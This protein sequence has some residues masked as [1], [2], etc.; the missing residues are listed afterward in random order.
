MRLLKRIDYYTL[1]QFTKLFLATFFVSLFVFL[2]QFLWKYVD[3]MVGKG[4]G[5]NVLAEF[6]FYA[7]VSLV[8][9]ALP[10]SIMLASLM[11]FGNMGEQLELLAMKSAGISLFRIMRALM[12]VITIA[13][14]GAFFFSN[15]ILP[16]SQTKMWALLI[17]MK[18][19]SPELEIPAGEFYK[20]ISGYSI[21][22]G[23][24][25]D[26]TQIL[27]RVMVYD[28]TN[29]FSNASVMLADSARLDVSPDKK[30]L[31]FTLYNGE[32]FENLQQQTIYSTASKIPYRRETFKFKQIIIDFDTNF[33]Q[34]ST[35]LLKNE[36]VSKNV[37]QLK[38][39]IDS[40]NKQLNIMRQGTQNMYQPIRFYGTLAQIHSLPKQIKAYQLSHYSTDS[41]FDQL[42]EAQKKMAVSATLSSLTQI[43]G[44]MTFNNI[45]IKETEEIIR[46]HAIDLHRK[47]ALSFACLVFFFIGAPLGAIIR[48]GGFGTPV[49]LSILMFIV[50]YIVD[51]TGTKMAREGIWPVWEG[52]WLSSAVLLPIGLF[53][54]YKA[55]KDST[56][57]N[58]ESY[59][60]II[61][62]TRKRIYRWLKT[63]GNNFISVI[64][65]HKKQS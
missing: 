3:D 55:V 28:F 22:V 46:R 14:I 60:D 2:M 8:P 61:K 1:T 49:V 23:A 40:L 25:N 48:K 7:S 41:L 30:F 11:T 29:G 16:K 59:S 65:K 27:K 20:G 51:N 32:S 24:K 64:L 33:T 21:Y 45:Q 62:K 15:D 43:K 10:M 56:L 38:A 53:L 50:Y 58:S 26:K 37:K 52:M 12:I 42:P 4:L 18:Q 39:T 19:K 57:M 31:I 5:L 54:T 9:L 34:F 63:I 47:F 36:N 44:E 35:S 17:S 6:F 13:V